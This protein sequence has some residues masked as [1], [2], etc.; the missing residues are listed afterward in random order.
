MSRCDRG[1]A[2]RAR[3]ENP[4]AYQPSLTK[5]LQKQSRSV[6]ARSHQA[7]PERPLFTGHPARKEPLKEFWVHSSSATSPPAQTPSICSIGST[8]ARGAGEVTASEQEGIIYNFGY[9]SQIILVELRNIR[10][11]G[12]GKDAPVARYNPT[13]PECFCLT[14][15]QI[16]YH[17]TTLSRLD[18]QYR[19]QTRT[20]PKN[21]ILISALYFPNPPRTQQRSWQPRP[22]KAAAAADRKFPKPTLAPFKSK[23]P[24]EE[25]VGMSSTAHPDI[26]IV[27]ARARVH[28]TALLWR[29]HRFIISYKH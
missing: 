21:I 3:S 18:A 20:A 2:D 24:R 11:R 4:R 27:C 12:R 6:I 19:V 10:A 26:T 9:F 7:A 28:V 29:C 16:F 5:T 23:V 15:Y 22:G 17:L 14:R 8:G 25:V 13:A 1:R